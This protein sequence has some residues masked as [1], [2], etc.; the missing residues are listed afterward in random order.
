MI[1][2]VRGSLISGGLCLSYCPGSLLTLIL[3]DI[4][5]VSSRSASFT[6]RFA[7]RAAWFRQYASLLW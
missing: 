3:G 1:S 2:A 4:I 6:W 5:S 7:V